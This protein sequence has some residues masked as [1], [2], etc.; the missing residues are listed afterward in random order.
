MRYYELTEDYDHKYRE[1]PESTF[2]HD[3]KEYK[4]D[5]VFKYIKDVPIVQFPLDKLLWMLEGDTVDPNYGDAVYFQREAD[6]D[7][8]APIIVTPWQDAWVVVDGMHRL[9]KAV[10]QGLESLPAKV[11]HDVILALAEIK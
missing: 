6:A 4:L 2:T 1:G 7:L 11:I 10:R 9:T 5:T 8:T 3:G